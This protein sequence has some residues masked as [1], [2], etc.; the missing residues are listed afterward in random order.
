MRL[1]RARSALVVGCPCG[2]AA[3]EVGERLRGE[4]RGLRG[5]VG[6]EGLE[7]LGLDPHPPPPP[8]VC[9]GGYGGLWVEWGGGTGWQRGL[10]GSGGSELPLH[11]VGNC[12][13][14]GR[15]RPVGFRCCAARRGAGLWGGWGAS[16]HQRVTAGRH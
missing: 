12:A 2:R 10:G 5:A 16:F 13:V 15:S 8:A 9:A 4:R 11:A 3:R 14:L 6:L 7:G 1:G